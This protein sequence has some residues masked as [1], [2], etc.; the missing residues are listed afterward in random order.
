MKIL[1]V[2]AAMLYA[3]RRTDMTKLIATNHNFVK[4]P[5]REILYPYHADIV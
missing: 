1:Q 2:E 5:K 4:A 3:D